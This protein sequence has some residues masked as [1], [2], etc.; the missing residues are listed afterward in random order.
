[1]QDLFDQH[2]HSPHWSGEKDYT[3][4]SDQGEKRFHGSLFFYLMTLSTNNNAK[5]CWLSIFFSLPIFLICLTAKRRKWKFRAHLE[6]W[7]SR[8]LNANFIKTVLA[9]ASTSC[10]NRLDDR[11][12]FILVISTT[13]E[14][15]QLFSFI[16]C[17]K[18]MIVFSR[19]YSV[20]DH[21]SPAI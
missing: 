1:M 20:A 10:T 19:F 12:S 2:H 16:D 4:S 15:L 13:I 18:W 3:I 6:R 17:S 7:Y 11:F 8:Y 9:V 14:D 5:K 21:A